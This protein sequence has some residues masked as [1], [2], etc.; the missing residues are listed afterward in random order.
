MSKHRR[1]PHRFWRLVAL[2]ASIAL[3]A[4]ALATLPLPT[5]PLCGSEPNHPEYCPSDFGEPWYLI[6]YVKDDYIENVRG[7]EQ[8]MG[9]GIALDKAYALETGDWNITIASLDSGIRWREGNVRRKHRLNTGELPLPWFADGTPATSHDLNGDGLVT[10]DDY[11]EDP[12]VSMAAGSDDEEADEMLDASDLI[13]TF[14]DG[15][16]QDGNGY[17]DD[18]AGWDF[19]WND[20]DPFDETENQGYSHGSIQIRRAAAEGGDGGSIGSC[21]NC[22]IMMLRIGDSFMS[23]GYAYSQA[24]LYAVDSGAKVLM[25]EIGGMSANDLTRDALEYAW[26][27]GV[28]VIAS[29]A[30]E[31]SMHAN[32]PSA[33]H[34]SIVVH[35]ITYSGGDESDSNSFLVFNNCSNF[36]GRPTLTIS[37][38][39]CSSEATGIG[40]G[41]AGLV[42]SAALHNSLELTSNEVYQLF[43]QAADDVWVPEAYYGSQ[44]QWYPSQEGFD[45]YFGY[46]RANIGRT[47][48]RINDGQI[49]P[50][51]D[52]LAPDWF[53]VLDPSVTPVI[54]VDGY[55]AANRSSSYSYVVEY[56]VG[57]DPAASD[58]Q[59]IAS[60]SNQTAP[61]QGSLALW[62]LTEIPH[63]LLDPTSAIPPFE[64]EDDNVTRVNKLNVHTLTV[65]V[66][67]TD[68]DGQ[69]AEMRKTVYLHQDP[70]VV[71]G[72]P[73]FLGASLEPSP[74]IIDLDGDGREEVIQATT[75]GFIHALRFDGSELPGWPVQT[76]RLRTLDPTLPGNHVDSP[77]YR[78]GAI[79]VD[80]SQSMLTAVAIGDLDNDGRLEVIVSTF[81]GEVNAWDSDGV[82][83]PG[84]PVTLDYSIAND[85]NA[86]KYNIVED[87]FFASPVLGDLDGDGYLDIVAGA[88]D[89]YV[90]AWDRFGTPLA[91]WPVKCEWPGFSIV[92]MIGARIVVAPAIGDV[93]ADG[94]LDVVVGTAEVIDYVYSPTYVLHGDGNAHP[95]G[96]Y[97]RGWPIKTQALYGWLLPDIGTG[98]TSAP[99]LADIDGDGLLE[100]ATHSVAGFTT[101]RYG[102]IY[103]ADGSIFIS[104]D[105]Q[106]KDFG[107][108]SNVDEPAIF[109]LLTSGAF[110]D[111]NQDGSLDYTIG[112]AGGSYLGILLV[113]NVIVDGT[114]STAAWDAN[115]GQLLDGFPQAVADM[116]LLNH[117][118]I[119]DLDGDGYPES[120]SSN[121]AFTV[122]AFDYQGNQPAGWPKF[123]GQ[124]GMATP[125][126]GD[127]DGDGR[128]ELV[129]GT[130]SGW[131]FAW[132]TEGPT[133]PQGGVIEWGEYRH[134]PY[135]SG[136]YNLDLSG[137]RP[138]TGLRLPSPAH[139][140]PVKMPSAA[141]KRVSELIRP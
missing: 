12:R 16:D 29:A 59:V 96:A 110:G 19:L 62:D 89:Q 23:E 51:A 41:L 138:V 31:A 133:A 79:D 104:V 15:V 84:F 28:T 35:P 7:E 141:S 52:I 27:K 68:A 124:W 108:L 14:S 139:K 92:P 42:Q 105:R 34:H 13:Y 38:D 86:G 73:I 74:K 56:G 98:T 130:R 65:R 88:M 119:A 90:Y 115:T 45:R 44:K 8:A 100:I 95:G 123:I 129:M 11:A 37:N 60:A 122:Q 43:I 99:A 132:H 137:I 46:G 111:L 136:N 118:M 113:N 50:E 127:L 102:S 125:A 78:S 5:Y 22:S 114:F 70:D 33:L 26:E 2:T 134:D 140:A 63:G 97:H 75:D 47:L 107:A 91:G 83:R 18:I 131:L 109:P 40:A 106:G 61:M 69:E 54:S 126:V 4:P 57:L 9:S 71:E 116:Q 135:N 87:G 36:G 128:L 117:Q 21:P 25:I 81:D 24:I 1:S 48:Q 39:G 10:I 121:G 58:F 120:I 103:R 30:D 82:Q 101:N 66:R 67:V 76:S 20:N 49:P 85:E 53:Q 112:M 93:N 72:F 55:V 32:L 6:S 64:L 80:R 3:C 17:V 94:L 77:A